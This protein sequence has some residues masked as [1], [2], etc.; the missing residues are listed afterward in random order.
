VTAFTQTCPS[1]TPDGGPF[2][3]RSWPAIQ[4]AQLTFGDSGAQTFTSAGGDAS[5]AQAFDPI[6]GTSD[7]CKTIPV[8][9][10][11]NDATYTHPVTEAFTMLGLPTIRAT[12]DAN[13]MFGQIDARLWDVAPD[14]TQRLISRGV[15]SLRSDQSGR[16]TF[17]LHGNG[18]RFAPGHT[19][20]LQLLGRDSPYYQ[21]G[22]FPVSVDVSDV[23]VTLPLLGR[24]H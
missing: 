12:I 16:I 7:A 9:D 20:E 24:P 14:D 2:V 4:R 15:Y 19:V 22:N 17:Q 3:A 13:G 1:S 21:A 11:P 5:V 10:E 18:Y 8:T 23:K 6:S